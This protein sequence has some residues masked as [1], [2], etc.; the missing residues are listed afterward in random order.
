MKHLLTGVLSSAA[1]FAVLCATPAV[2]NGNGGDANAEANQAQFIRGKP[3]KRR[4]GL[5][6][7]SPSASSIL[8][9]LALTPFMGRT[10]KGRSGRYPPRPVPA[11]WFLTR[12]MAGKPWSAGR[13]LSFDHRD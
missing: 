12:P 11:H 8:Q 2:A 7:R 10:A 6:V 5:L 3:I 9:S 4:I 1:V 13:S